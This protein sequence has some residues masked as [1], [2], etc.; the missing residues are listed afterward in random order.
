MLSLIFVSGLIALY[1]LQRPRPRNPP[2]LKED[3]KNHGKVPAFEVYPPKEI[4]PEKS[5]PLPEVPK[6]PRVAI[7]IDDLGY[8]LEIANRFLQIEEPITLSVLPDGAFKRIL[9]EAHRR[10]VETLLHLPMEPMEYPRIDPGPG[11]LLTTMAPDALI[12][13]LEKHLDRMQTIRGVNNHMGSKMTAMSDQMYQIF[14]TLKKRNLF[15]ID[16]RTTSESL[17]R[18]SARLLKVP[19]AQRDVFLDHVPKSD[20]IRKQLR[21]L[22]RTAARQGYAIGIGHPHPVTLDVV[23]GELPKMKGTVDFVPASAIVRI[24]G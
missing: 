10:G 8:D 12:A 24:V 9:R 6:R 22:I 4:P 16:S 13:Q 21:Q 18:P 7:I 23:R 14:S 19:F 5:P 3:F 15:F 20:F 11:A 2:L 17:S 1:A